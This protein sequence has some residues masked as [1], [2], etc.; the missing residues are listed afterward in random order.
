MVSVQEHQQEAENI[1]IDNTALQDLHLEDLLKLVQALP[2]M[3]KA[4]FNLYVFDGFSHRE[5]ADKLKMTEATSRW[6]ILN[7]RKQLQV[8]VKALELHWE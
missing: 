6:H 2:T 1:Y 3:T 5:I 8:K 4:V 7:A